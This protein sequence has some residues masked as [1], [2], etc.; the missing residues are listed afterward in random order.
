MSLVPRSM[1]KKKVYKSQ[2]CFCFGTVS[3]HEGKY[4]MFDSKKN[5]TKFAHVREVQVEDPLLKDQE[6][7]RGNDD[8]FTVINDV[9]QLEWFFNPSDNGGAKNKKKKSHGLLKAMK[10]SVETKV[11]TQT[12]YFSDY[13][14]KRCGFVQ[15]LYSSV[16]GGLYKGFQLNFKVFSCVD[17]EVKCDVWESFKLDEVSAFEPLKF[18]SK[19]VSF[20]FKE[21]EFKDNIYDKFATLHIR[22][23]IPQQDNNVK[24][25]KLEM[26]VSLLPGFMINPDGCNYYLDKAVALDK[27]YSEESNK[28]IRH[29]FIPKGV[30]DGKITYKKLNSKSGKYDDFSILLTNSPIVYIDAVQGLQPNKA[31]SRWNFLCFQSEHHSVLCMEFTTTSEHGNKT[32]TIWS[33][34]E[35][36]KL[37]TIGSSL[38][39]HKVKFNKTHKDKENG[40]DYPTS[41]QFPADF[42]EDHL[43][44]INR[45]DVL[46]ELPGVVKSVAQNIAHIKPY[47][48]QYCQESTY[49]NEKGVSIVE[50]TFIS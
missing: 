41:I 14:S 45:Y 13:K 25:L 15:L 38:D 33:T 7:R 42:H 10:Q 11:E 30:A 6:D 3:S 8:A 4:G 23:D 27:L 43:R 12:L 49:K 21:I 44:L 36:G 24:D 18:V 39:K 47:I 48:Y 35:D 40:W 50:S 17:E 1:A 37:K 26:D 9:S 31:A 16:L 22:A 46:G 2:N 28:M 19:N 34:S 29:V 20:E 32:M 5:K